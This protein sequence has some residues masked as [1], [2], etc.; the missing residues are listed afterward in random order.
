MNMDEL[1][2]LKQT[3]EMKIKQIEEKYFSR[4][5]EILNTREVIF[6]QQDQWETKERFIDSSLS[7]PTYGRG[8]MPQMQ[9]NTFMI[10][11][12]M[13]GQQKKKKCADPLQQSP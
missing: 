13:T 5:N 11:D 12:G 8:L 7:Y 1:E 2:Q 6:Q 3:N 10:Q 9:M 4:K